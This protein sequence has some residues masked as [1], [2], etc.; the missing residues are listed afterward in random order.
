[1]TDCYLQ[2]C[3]GFPKDF[4]ATSNPLENAF[5]DKTCFRM[6]GH[7]LSLTARSHAGHGV[8]ISMRSKDAQKQL[9]QTSLTPA[10]VPA[11]ILLWIIIYVYLAVFKN[12]PSRGSCYGAL[13][14][15]SDRHIT[16][17]A[18]TSYLIE[19]NASVFLFQKKNYMYFC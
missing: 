17:A 19:T 14:Q 8:W 16:S 13:L 11:D 10:R 5:V 18:T 7:I 9:A 1:M 3:K 2:A 15:L 6:E 12:L 4:R